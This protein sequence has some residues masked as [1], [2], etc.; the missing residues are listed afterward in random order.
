MDTT[1]ILIAF[2]ILVVLVNLVFFFGIAWRD[3]GTEGYENWR[4]RPPVWFSIFLPIINMFNLVRPL[5]E[6]TAAYEALDTKLQSAGFSYA[7]KPE[8]FS[9]SRWVGLLFGIGFVLL[10]VYGLSVSNSNYIML[11][12]VAIPLGFFYPDIWLNDAVKVRQ[13]EISKQFPFFLELLVLSMRAGLNFTSALEHATIKLPE[14]ALKREL[15]HLVRDIRTGLSRKDALDLMAKRVAMPEVSNFVAAIN[16]AEEVGG[17]LG[18]LLYKQAIQRRK[19]RFLRAEE[20]AGKA[21]VKM[22]GPL[23]VLIFPMT[24]VIIGWVMFFKAKQS[25]IDIVGWLLGG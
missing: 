25:G 5:Q 17:E 8:E 15:Q 7:I 12:M 13:T 2:L 21:P 9:A 4:D 22:L 19:E 6:G 14:G 24:F 23:I 20:L 11:S 18:D 10:L 16:Q 1:L 3:R